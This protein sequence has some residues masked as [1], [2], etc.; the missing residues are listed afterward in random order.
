MTKNL[1]TYAIN[2]FGE[3]VVCIF[4]ENGI[5]VYIVCVKQNNYKNIWNF[6]E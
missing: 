5:E 6:K 1:I 3:L 4:E 2:K